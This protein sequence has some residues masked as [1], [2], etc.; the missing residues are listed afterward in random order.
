MIVSAIIPVAGQGKRFG[1]DTPKQ[2]LKIGNQTV[3]EVTLNKFIT[4]AEIDYGV[5]VVNESERS[6]LEDQ[7]SQIDGFDQ[8]FSIIDGG[9]ERQDSVYNGLKNIPPGTDIVVVHDGVRPLVSSRLIGNSI[10]IAKNTGACIAALPVQDTIK[11]VKSYI[12]QETI[13]RKDLWQVQTPQTFQY[14]ILMD[15]HEKARKENYYSTDE[16]AL[17][18]WNG[19]PVTITPGEHQNIKI[20]TSADLELCRYYY[21]ND[22]S[23]S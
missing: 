12:V 4:L 19:H 18:E 14:E 17:V 2:F 5:V 21:Q 10:Q 22:Q 23:D 6:T 16:S 20:T 7:F 15:A 13:S 9:L 11:R 1:G 8:R 3:I